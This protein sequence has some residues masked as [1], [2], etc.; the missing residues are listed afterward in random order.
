M[1]SGHG[2]ELC[3]SIELSKNE[4]I[5]MLCFEGCPL[6]VG[7][8]FNKYIYEHLVYSSELFDLVQKIQSAE[9]LNPKLKFL[10]KIMC[11]Y[12]HQVPD[13]ILKTSRQPDDYNYRFGIFELPIKKSSAKYTWRDLAFT[14]GP[15]IRLTSW[16][17]NFS[18]SGYQ[19]KL[20]QLL[21]KL[22]KK[23]PEGFT[24]VLFTCRDFER[25]FYGINLQNVQQKMIK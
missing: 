4:Q 2:S 18:R 23:S 17:N 13:M 11:L 16:W 25:V 14:S 8:E 7:P 9:Q 22:R 21:S 1:F 10:K 24:L 12:Q 15:K 3:P 5:I 6:Y 19:I 20:S